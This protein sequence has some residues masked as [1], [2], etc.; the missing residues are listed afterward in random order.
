MAH[1]TILKP[2]SSPNGGVAVMNYKQEGILIGFSMMSN[3]LTSYVSWIKST[4]L[5]DYTSSWLWTDQT[6]KFVFNWEWD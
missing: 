6:K 4:I 3:P 1:F 5:R 2:A